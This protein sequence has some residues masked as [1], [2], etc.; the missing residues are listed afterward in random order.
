MKFGSITT[1][2]ITDGLVFNM[3]A[4][5]RASTIPSTS[6]LKTFNTIDTAISGS[7]VT[8]ATWV[9][10][11]PPTFNFDGS[12]GYILTNYLG[13]N[14]VTKCVISIWA[15]T[16]NVIEGNF[17]Y[18]NRDSNPFPG[19][20]CQTWTDGRI[21]FYVASNAFLYFNMANAG[22]QNN[23]WFNLVF[24]FNGSGSG[25]IDKVKI[26]VN[27]NIVNYTNSSNFPS[28]LENSSRTLTIGYEQAAN[29]YWNGD[30][31]PILIYNRALSAG[32]VL[33]NYNRLKGRFDLS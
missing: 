7:I 3:D 14:S 19:I 21:Y 15:K 4:A 16:S 12:D 10:G 6:T 25:N 11:T 2:I 18:G 23:N 13:I 24:V 5:N 31:G 28:S 20:G 30:I 32:E 1:G 29:S 17:L 8:D 22:I 26:Y 9:N 33:Q 27:S